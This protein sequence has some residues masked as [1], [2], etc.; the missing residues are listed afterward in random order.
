[1][2]K[3]LKLTIAILL[4]SAFPIFILYCI[5]FDHS[6]ESF[7][8]HVATFAFTSAGLKLLN[9][10]IKSKDYLLGERCLKKKK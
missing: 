7:Q 5:F 8:Y 4:I 9:N 2:K 10:N 3:L 6:Y 1:M